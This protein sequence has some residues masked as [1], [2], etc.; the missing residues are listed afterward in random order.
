MLALCCLGGG[1]VEL[2]SLSGLQEQLYGWGISMDEETLISDLESLMELE[3][4]QL[5]KDGAANWY[6]PAIPLMGIWINYQQDIVALKT[7]AKM[8][9]ENPH[10]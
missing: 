5:R 1:K 7:R 10:E 4:I 8:E 2:F 9:A 6:A 3:L